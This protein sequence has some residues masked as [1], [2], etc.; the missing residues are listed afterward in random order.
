MAMALAM[1]SSGNEY[2]GD[3]QM[4]TRITRVTMA[5]S[6]NGNEYQWQRVTVAMSISG[7]E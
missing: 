1:G 7:N 4:A 6:N 5:T 3:G 2:N